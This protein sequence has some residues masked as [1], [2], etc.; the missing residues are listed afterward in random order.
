MT[1]KYHKFTQ[2]EID[3]ISC[4]ALNLSNIELTDKFNKHFNVN[5]PIHSIKSIKK[6]H[7]IKTNL[8]H[9][10]SDE[11]KQFIYDNYKKYYV[12]DLVSLF[13]KKFGTNLNVQ[14]IAHFKHSE[15][16]YHNYGFKV[17]ELPRKHK[18]PLGYELKPLSTGQIYIKVSKDKGKKNFVSKAKY[19]YEQKYGKIP[20]GFKVFH[21]DGDTTNNKIENLKLV[22]HENL[23]TINLQQ[24]TSKNKLINEVAL[25]IAELQI[26]K[27][28][29]KK[30]TV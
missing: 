16:L 22:K 20:E 17:W 15:K 19:L 25:Q 11:E 6:N 9:I 28:E 30:K 29:R 1:R 24:L 10:F 12:R 4:N 26:A 13:N 23:A 14:N 21:I 2:E 3:F 7:Q 18:R 8:R 5:V 27:N